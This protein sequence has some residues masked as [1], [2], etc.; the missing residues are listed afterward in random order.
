MTINKIVRKLKTEFNLWVLDDGTVGDSPQ[1]VMEAFET[2]STMGEEVG[3]HLN[4]SKCEVGFIGGSEEG[5][6]LASEMFLSTLPGIQLKT[7]VQP[8]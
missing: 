5:R 8:S 1:Q 4:I 3:L 7:I 2:I 6:I